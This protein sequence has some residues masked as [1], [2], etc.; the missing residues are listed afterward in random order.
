LQHFIYN[1]S[2]LLPLILSSVAVSAFCV[3]SIRATPIIIVL[4]REC[5]I[6]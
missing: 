1:V 6:D 3:M 2:V 4:Y 5:K